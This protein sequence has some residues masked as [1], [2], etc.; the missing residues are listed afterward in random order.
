MQAH[1]VN[2]I[3]LLLALIGTGKITLA[4]D[5]GGIVARAILDGSK[6]QIRP[7]SSRTVEDTAFF[8]ANTS[9]LDTA[10]SVQ[11][12]ITLKINEASPLYLRTAF[13]A[14]VHVWIVYSNGSAV[15]SIERDLTI[16]YDSAKTYN[17]RN[18]FAF[19]GGRRV[20]VRTDPVNTHP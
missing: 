15:D 20:T 11:N 14:T 12:L 19:N 5:G 8:N 16:N 13:K 10:Y 4:G 6:H 17:S 7:D 9:T 3:L 18:R 2:R 1:I